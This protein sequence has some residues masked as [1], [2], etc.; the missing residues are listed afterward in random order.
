MFT[1]K[2]DL[3]IMIKEANS[4]PG[5]AEVMKVYSTYTKVVEAAT[6]YLMLSRKPSFSITDSKTR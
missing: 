3:K 6:P 5:V 1:L 2:D 4:R